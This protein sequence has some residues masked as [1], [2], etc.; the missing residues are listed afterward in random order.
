[1]PKNILVF[2]DGTGNEG[3][4]LPDESR[5]NV[6]K[7]YRAT[8]TGPDST[9]DP[10]KQLAFYVPGIGTPA[11][12]HDT[13]WD[14]A[15]EAVRQMFGLGLTQKI[16]DCYVA[17]I[18]T[19]QPGD[20][21]YLFGFSRGAYTARCVSHVLEV[22]GI[23]T[24]EPGGISLNLDPKSLRKVAAAA[25]SCLYALG[26][27]RNE[28][29]AAARAGKFRKD[30]AAQTGAAAG[31]TAFM[32]G[33]WDAVAAIGWQRFF[34]DWAY[35][36]HF[37]KDVR[38]AR[39][40]QSIDEGR[41]DFK[42]VAWGGSGTVLEPDRRDEPEQFDQ[43][44]FAGNH[45]DIGGSYPENESR[46]SDIT[47][48]WM[49]EFISRKIPEP[50][51]VM[52]DPDLLRLYPSSDGMMHDECMVGIGGTPLH[53]QRAVRDVQD[54]AQLHETVYER[55]ALPAVRNFTSYGPYRPAALRNHKK[56]KKFY[57]ADG[58]KS[59]QQPSP[60]S[61]ATSP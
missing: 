14:R 3:G 32:V 26:M 5:T 17:I 23:P 54:T 4:L 22:C 39:H 58:Q 50:W 29:T 43:I 10:S 41:S 13:R 15:K 44:W 45:A 11:P 57:D 51:R 24:K 35:D 28:K 19:W 25:V 18:G 55:L 9:I 60:A 59:G 31:A 38:Y 47:L 42:R 27:P 7:L 16:I 1:M 8:R 6:Y 2:A 30:H 12:R 61:P 56:A 34:P 37:A 53:W 49:V 36:R 40:L 46:L 52:V 21:I 48:R 20:R 33:V